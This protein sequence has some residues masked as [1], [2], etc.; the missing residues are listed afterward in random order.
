MLVGQD[1]V[2]RNAESKDNANI[3]ILKQQVWISTYATE[4]I[5]EEFS[6]YVLKKFTIEN[7]AKL[8]S[9]PNQL[10]LLAEIQNH[11]IGIVDIDF[12]PANPIIEVDGLPEVTT[13]YILDRFQKSGIGQKLL[14][15]SILKIKE[16]GYNSLWLTVYHLNSNALKFYDK[17]G[18]KVI[19]DTYFEMSGNKY[20]NKIL[21]KEF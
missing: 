12:K 13:L 18:F 14:K 2:I 9:D 16:S 1:I 11:L 17:N 7:T 8:I 20:L 6:E 15:E 5:R 4:G 3:T 19:G 10:C 21:L